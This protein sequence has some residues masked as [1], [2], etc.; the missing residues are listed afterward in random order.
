MGE[1]AIRLLKFCLTYRGWQTISTSDRKA[2]RAA[3][4][5]VELGFC[6]ENEHRQIRAIVGR[7]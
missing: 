5:L 4:R 6:E 1:Q 2:K 7:W 3:R